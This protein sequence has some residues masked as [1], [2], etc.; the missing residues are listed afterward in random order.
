MSIEDR[1]TEILGQ[2]EFL[3][4]NFIVDPQPPRCACGEWQDSG[5][6]ANRV[7]ANY[8]EHVARVLVTELGLTEELS[9]SAFPEEAGKRRRYVT[10][11]EPRARA[12]GAELTIQEES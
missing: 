1:I 2:H 10:P 11:W 6:G 9:R 3:P 12:V 7:R 8:L 5:P 4:G